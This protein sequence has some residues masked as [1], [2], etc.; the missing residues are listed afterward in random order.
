LLTTLPSQAINSFIHQPKHH[1]LTKH[2]LDNVQQ[3]ALC[4]VCEWLRILHSVQE[5]VSA[6]KTPTL[7][8]VLPLYEQLIGM[9]KK[10]VRILP[11]IAHTIL[12]SMEKLEEYMMY[13]C[14]S[15]VYAIA[16]SENLDFNLFL[17]I[18]DT[19]SN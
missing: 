11:K 18:V 10:M 15:C 14:Q 12:F 8:V 2:E 17:S 9:L 5:L 7:S 6:E 19:F 1:E 4:D 16:M 3:K 13:S